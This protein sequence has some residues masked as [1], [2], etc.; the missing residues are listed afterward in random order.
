MKRFGYIFAPMIMA[1][2]LVLSG[3]ASQGT[4]PFSPALGS[5][6]QQVQNM[7]ADK[8]IVYIYRPSPSDG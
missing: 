8:A 5:S 3:C 4:I 6:F 1:G 2:V 7:A